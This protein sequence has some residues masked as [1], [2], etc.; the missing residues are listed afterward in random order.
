ML[1]WSP[2]KLYILELKLPIRP[3]FGIGKRV[4][5]WSKIDP[6]SEFDDAGDV[7]AEEQTGANNASI[8]VY[9]DD[10]PNAGEVGVGI[11]LKLF[12]L[13]AVRLEICRV[14]I[15]YSSQLGSLNLTARM[16]KLC[17]PFAFTITSSVCSSQT[18]LCNG[19]VKG[20][21]RYDRG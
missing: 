17:S 9:P 3:V 6:A 4:S 16:S 18:I 12:E 1:N 2:Q 11:D 7:S 20:G 10:V 8:L 21:S 13:L 19:K 14:S 15:G 5:G